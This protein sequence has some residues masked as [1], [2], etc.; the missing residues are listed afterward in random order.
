MSEA[1]AATTRQFRFS[2]SVI[3]RFYAR[4]TLR[5]GLIW[6][7]AFAVIALS[8]ATGFL[9][10]YPTEAS[11]E[12]F[13]QTF[14]GNIG[15]KALLGVMN[16]I[17]TAGGFTAWR[18]L[19]L[20]MMVGSIWGIMLATKIFRG[21]EEKGRTEILLTGITSKR[22]ASLQTAFGIGVTLLVMFGVI[23]GSVWALGANDAKIGWTAGQSAFYAVTLLAPPVLFIAVGMFTS[24]LFPTRSRALSVAGAIFGASFLLRAVGDITSGVHWLVYC[25]PLGWVES[26][27]PLTNPRPLWLMPIAIFALTLVLVSAIIAGQRDLAASTFGDKDTAKPHTKLL[28]SVLGLTF[29][30]SRATLLSWF[31]ALLLVGT[32]FGSLAKSAANAINASGSAGNIINRIAHSQTAGAETFLGIVFFMLMSLLM[33]MGAGALNSARNDEAEGYLD[34]LLV[35]PVSR[36]Q[37]IATRLSLAVVAIVIGGLIIA[38][39]VWLGQASQHTGIAAHKLF[40]AGVNA[41]VPALVVGGVGMLA[42]GFMPRLVSAAGYGL[43]AWSFLLEMLGSA[44]NLNHWILDTSLLHHI[45][46]APAADIDW[47]RNAILLAIAVACAAAGILRFLRRDLA[48][49]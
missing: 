37:W 10:A 48:A 41:M 9:A 14:Q 39:G 45:V 27:Q 24:Q 28:N 19:G 5:G 29:R 35:R 17:D 4:Q 11:R 34:N 23:F 15:I 43:V 36:W 12:V 32:M 31:G 1:V 46:L 40:L 20:S 21:E 49:E 38:S 6:A 26:L 42:M 2:R 3:T 16:H 22:H 18:S 25:S 7:I 47:G 33:I 13:V 30:L 44:I 8:S